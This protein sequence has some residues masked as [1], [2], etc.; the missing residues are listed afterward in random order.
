MT[1]VSVIGLG[2]MGS[3]LASTFLDRGHAVTVWNRT[4]V[5]ADPL[6][7]RGAV[8]APAVADAVAAGG[9][10]VVCV[11]D[12]AAAGAVLDEAAG[13]LGG[14]AVVNLTNGTPAQARALARRMADRGARYVD[15][16]IMAVPPMIGSPEALLLL[17]GDG[18]AF[19]A[20]RGAL[21]GLGGLTWLG[22]DP[23]HACLYDLALLA[24]MYG[25]FA[26]FL[27]ATAMVGSERV[28]ASDFL[29]LLAPWIEAM[30][31]LLPDL[32]R[33]VDDRDYA[34]DGGSNLAMQAVGVENILQAARDQGVG[35]ELLEP[36]LSL[37]RRRV[38]DGFGGDDVPGLIELIRF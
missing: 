34:A 5:K 38:A 28:A 2:A 36:M 16:G 1:A 21:S 26:G 15:G 24:G 11:L 20:H 13:A 25:L 9:L 4:P 31:G 29:A 3:A 35:T 19:E 14:R 8:R 23:G 22:A 33:Q 7:A 30:A 12:Y 32:A 6:V 10:V 18:D 17:S 27:Q 37:M